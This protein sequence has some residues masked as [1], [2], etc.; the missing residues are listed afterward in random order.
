MRTPQVL[1]GMRFGRLHVLTE[2]LGRKT[3]KHRFF[4]CRCECGNLVTCSMNHLKSGHTRSC[5]CVLYDFIQSTKVT[6]GF[7]RRGSVK[8]EYRIWQCMKDRCYNLRTPAYED[9]GARGITVCNRWLESFQNFLDD[10][11]VRP[12]SKLTLDRI[13][14][15]G[16]YEP[17]N[18][19]WATW[20]QQRMNSRPRPDRPNNRIHCTCPICGEPFT[21]RPGEILPTGNYCSISHAWKGRYLRK[22]TARD[23]HPAANLA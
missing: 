6:H 11:G 5:G 3:V 17:T 4:V 19:R 21:R 8:S 20:H 12:S 15:D 1:D 18:T 7:A 10:V 9:Y 23:N 2:D 14:N 22:S 13:N 16:N